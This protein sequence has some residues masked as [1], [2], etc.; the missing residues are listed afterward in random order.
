VAQKAITGLQ[1]M[2]NGIWKIDKKYRGER[3]QESTGTCNR[4]EAEQYLIHKLEQLR[5][6]GVRTA[7]IG[8]RESLMQ[9]TYYQLRDLPESANATLAELRQGFAGTEL[10]P[11][12][13]A[14]PVPMAGS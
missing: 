7:Q 11:C 3:I 8:P 13:N 5:E 10:K 9:M 2:P 6:K 4:A 14:V 12:G 1:Q